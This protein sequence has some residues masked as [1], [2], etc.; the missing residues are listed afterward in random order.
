[1]PITAA[2]PGLKRN[3][4]GAILADKIGQ[5]CVPALGVVVM[6]KYL[7]LFGFTSETVKRFVENP[8]DRAAVV[9]GLVE[10]VGGSL[11]CYYWMFGQHDGMAIVEMPDSHTYAAAALAIIS[12][13]AFRHFETHELMDADD[14]PEIAERARQ[15]AYQPPGA[16]RAYRPGNSAYGVNPPPRRTGEPGPP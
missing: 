14:L 12:S 1:V 5:V 6:A 2:R 3:A 8:S 4:V 7:A 10:S 16:R 11:Q 13:G 15:V 9:R